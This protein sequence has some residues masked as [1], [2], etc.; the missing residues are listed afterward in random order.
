MREKVP[1]EKKIKKKCLRKGPRKKRVERETRS[2]QDG[3]MATCCCCSLQKIC[4]M[5]LFF[6]FIFLLSIQL[7]NSYIDDRPHIF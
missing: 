7:I 4:G 2:G 1:P 3:Q 6:I 5:F